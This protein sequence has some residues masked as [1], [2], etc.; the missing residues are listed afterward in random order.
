MMGCRICGTSMELDDIGINP[1]LCRWCETSYQRA[2]L[3]ERGF[4]EILISR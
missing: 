1:V 2:Y 4:A 3:K